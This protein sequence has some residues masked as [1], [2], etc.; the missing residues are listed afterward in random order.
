MSWLVCGEALFDMFGEETPGGFDFDARIGGSPFNVAVGLARMGRDA[1]LFTG[2]GRDLLGQRLAKALAAEGVR[3]ETLAEKAAPT[4]LGFVSLDEGGAAQYAFYGA[5]AADRGVALADIPEP[6]YYADGLHFGSYSLVVEPTGTT[7]LTLA[8]R[9]RG[10]RLITL[11]PNLR[12]NVDPDV[13]LW[14]QRVAAFAAC[15]DLVKVSDED[16]RQLHP[17]EAQAEVA[18]RW[19]EGG[20]ALVVVTG[21]GEG[22]TAYGAFGEVTI[23]A[24]PVTVVDTVGAGDTFQAALI[25]GLLETGRARREALEGMTADAAGALLDFAAAAAAITCGRRGANLPRRDE[26]PPLSAA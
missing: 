16:L 14:R 11:D 24:R 6:A 25:A 8:Q 20:A 13:E 23:P 1:A 22:A 2:V 12:L 4:T 7:F 15:A 9:E 19:R 26:L 17:G 21:G 3:T 5:G 18:A 10:K